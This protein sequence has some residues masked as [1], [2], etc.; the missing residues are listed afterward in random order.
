VKVLLARWEPLILES[1]PPQPID[2]SIRLDLRCRGQF[3][4]VGELFFA[5]LQ[6]VERVAKLEIWKTVRLRCDDGCEL[7]QALVGVVG[8]WIIGVSNLTPAPNIVC[9]RFD[10]G[11]VLREP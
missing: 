4:D 10:S 9:S 2:C 3:Q 5:V 1:Q 11:A 6:I 8:S 7:L